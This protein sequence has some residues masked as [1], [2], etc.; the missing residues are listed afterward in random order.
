MAVYSRKG[1]FERYLPL[2]VLLCALISTSLFV[3]IL[4]KDYNRPEEVKVVQVAVLDTENYILY[5]LMPQDSFSDIA[6]TF[7]PTLDHLKVI[8]TISEMNSVDGI[9]YAYEMIKLPNV[10]WI[11]EAVQ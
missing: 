10:R 1:S 3:A 7:Y 5:Q 9:Y 4:W 11:E 8:E 6:K 2:V